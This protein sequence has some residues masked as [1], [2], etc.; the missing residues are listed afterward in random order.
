MPPKKGSKVKD[1][2]K[3]ESTNTVQPT[4]VVANGSGDILEVLDSVVEA[5]SGFSVTENSGKEVERPLLDTGANE[6][7]TGVSNGP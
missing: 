2:E 4:N 1:S 5:P 6:A 3:D 7:D